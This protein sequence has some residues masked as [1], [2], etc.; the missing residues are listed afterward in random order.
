MDGVTRTP[1]EMSYDMPAPAPLP[2]AAQNLRAAIEVETTLAAPGPWLWRAFVFG[3][4]LIG[5]G[6]LLSF[7]YGFFAAKEGSGEVTGLETALLA[8]I[9]ITFAWII[10]SVATIAAA[11]VHRA[12]RP[13]R[14]AQAMPS[15]GGLTTALLVPVYNECPA[16]VFGNAAA[17]LEDLD[18]QGS[19]HQYSLF[20]LSDTRSEDIAAQEWQAFLWL[21]AQ[22]PR[23]MAVHYRRRVEN[24][25]KKTGN[26]AQ[27]I[28]S[29]GAAYEAMLVLDADSLMS[30][31]A[32]RDLADAMRDDPS[33]G[34]IQ[35]FPGLIGAETLFG[36]IQQFSNAT[37]SWLLAEGLALWTK[38]EG[39]YWGHNAIVRTRAFAASAGLPHLRTWGGRRQVIFSHDFVEAGLLRRAGWAVRF[40]AVGGS[41]EETPAT[42]V[43]YVLRD[44]R[45]CLGNL[46]HL[47]LLGTAG[48]HPLSRFHL[49]FGAISYLMSPA[50]LLLLTVWSILGLTD[51]VP[52]GYFRESNPMYPLWPAMSTS[53]A[54][55][56]LLFMYGMLL[57]P[58][59]AASLMIASAPQVRR[60]YGGLGAFW[61]GVLIEL[62]VSILYAPIMMVQ[63]S[64]SVVKGI[65]G[66]SASWSPQRRGAA[67][68]PLGQLLRFHAIE[69]VLGLLLTAGLASGLL[70]LW[71]L[72]IAVSLVLAVPLSAMSALDI[73]RAKLRMGRLETPQ[74][75]YAP[76]IWLRAKKA[77]AE[78]SDHLDEVVVVAAE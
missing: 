58:K 67:T 52:Q 71:L 32:I 4:T 61:G 78:L 15:D 6:V 30:G 14:R 41:F 50:W 19:A 35:S 37:Y 54:V 68:I 1:Q 9:G 12:G 73:S 69:T 44:R 75:L 48:F 31:Q 60:R 22:A 27:W 11:L 65:L 33:V 53:Q 24:T 28:R 57:L 26:L 43:D 16:S 66:S 46:Q 51:M 45:W 42:L 2:F 72:P 8:I 36:R 3:L 70:S 20:I 18:R 13:A 38:N 64:L 17:M 55:T 74:S 47:R 76:A 25:D 40:L 34:L 77:R 49:F 29:W 63:Q 23:G 59:I 39:N 5:T 56:F 21:R 10:L 62:L 7:L